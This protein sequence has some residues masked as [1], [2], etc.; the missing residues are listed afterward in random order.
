[1]TKSTFQFCLCSGFGRLFKDMTITEDFQ[2]C[3]CRRRQRKEKETYKWR[4]GEISD[5][6]RENSFI[7]RVNMKSIVTSN[8]QTVLNATNTSHIT[9]TATTVE[10]S[11]YQV[12]SISFHP[13]GNN[14]IL[15]EGK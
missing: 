3:F 5:R 9:E 7:C 8:G 2:Q 14:E 12:L 13:P 6:L 4:E 15:S 10:V 1:M 11:A